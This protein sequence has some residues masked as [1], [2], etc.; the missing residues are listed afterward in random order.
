MVTVLRYGHVNV[1]LLCEGLSY[2]KQKKLTNKRDGTK[3]SITQNQTKIND[4]K[5][6][7]LF[8]V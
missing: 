6:G 3:Q 7:L 8:N 4:V 1:M 2:N 5:L